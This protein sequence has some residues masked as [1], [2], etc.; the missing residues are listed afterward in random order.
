MDNI[1]ISAD[2]KTFV[3]S[4]TVTKSS[5]S[6]MLGTWRTDVNAESSSR[7]SRTCLNVKQRLWYVYSYSSPFQF[8]IDFKKT[9]LGTKNLDF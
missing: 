9:H 1:L 3:S 6:E 5:T 8:Q 7:S 4:K 2:E